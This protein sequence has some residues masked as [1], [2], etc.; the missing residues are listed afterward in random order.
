MKIDWSLRMWKV[1]DDKV[2]A[3]VSAPAMASTMASS[4]RRGVDFS[5]SEVS[6]SRI[7]WKMVLL[8][9]EVFRARMSSIL[10]PR[11]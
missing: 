6:L 9:E 8:S 2:A 3:V 7:S 11:S 1:R 4:I 10:V 5:S